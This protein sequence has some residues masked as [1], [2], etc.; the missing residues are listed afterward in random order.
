MIGRCASFAHSLSHDVIIRSLTLY[1]DVIDEFTHL[2]RVSVES[3]V[4]EAALPPDLQ[5][6]IL[7]SSLESHSHMYINRKVVGWILPYTLTT[8]DMDHHVIEAIESN[9]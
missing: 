7:I 5:T 2:T 4:C 1:Y 9:N 8:I 3:D 6:L